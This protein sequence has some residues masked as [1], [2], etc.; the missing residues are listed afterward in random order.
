MF[1][2]KSCSRCH[3]DLYEDHDIHGSYVTCLQCSHYLTM[4]DE[5]I[6]R[7]TS[8]PSEDEFAVVSAVTL[9]E[10]PRGSDWEIIPALAENL[11]IIKTS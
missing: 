10:V 9:T 8:L 11:S 5:A 7:E 1:W 4:E 3:G 6:L 2:L